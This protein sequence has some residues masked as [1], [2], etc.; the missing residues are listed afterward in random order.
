MARNFRVG[1][2]LGGMY[3]DII[4]IGDDGTTFT[5]KVLSTPGDY[6]RAIIGGIQ[7]VIADHGLSA[8]DIGESVHGG[9][10]VT[11]ACVQ[12][13]GAKI[14][15]FLQNHPAP[16]KRMMALTRH[17]VGPASISLTPPPTESEDEMR[18]IIAGY[19]SDN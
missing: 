19:K 12:L 17:C 9:G 5:K 18:E 8:S 10:I 4:F 7:D 15:L 2:D 6:A 1:V 3:T 14:G 16:I 11:N 13:T